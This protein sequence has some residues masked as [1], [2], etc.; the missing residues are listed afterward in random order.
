MITQGDS[1]VITADCQQGLALLGALWAP[2]QRLSTP[3]PGPLS[4]LWLCPFPLTYAVV[5]LPAREAQDPAPT[6]ITQSTGNTNP[7][8]GS[9][10]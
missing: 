7:G 5:P 9:T 8:D 4:P 1:T 3:V 10:G 2:G 6:W